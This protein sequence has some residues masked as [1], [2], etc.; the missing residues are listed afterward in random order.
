M[1]TT[2]PIRI[3]IVEDSALVRQG[4]TSLL[5][6]STDPVMQVVGE[7]TSNAEAI[8]A[9]EEHKPDVVLLDIRLPDGPGFTACKE[10][11]K[12]QPDTRII[13]L[14]SHSSD[15]FVYE[16]VSAGVH[17]YLM[18]EIDPDGLI[19]GIR[20]VSEGKSI[21]APDATERVLNFLRA[22]S[23]SPNNHDELAILSPQE[24]K[25]LAL[26]ADGFTNKQ[27][28]SSLNLSE[29]TVK[30]YLISVFEKLNVKRRAQ[31][32]AVYVQ[33]TRTTATEVENASRHPFS[34]TSGFSL[35]E[36]MVAAFVM[37]LGITTAITTLQQGLKAVDSAR[38]YSY[39]AQLMQSELERLRLKSWSQI[40]TL[41]NSGS[42]KVTTD[43]TSSSARTVFTCKRV[44]TDVKS[45]MKEI[46]VISNWQGYDGRPHTARFITR[47]SKSGLYDYIYTAH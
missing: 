32:A 41:Q 16:A 4:V 36:V 30:N 22:G 13:I 21:L 1:N 24:K 46:T 19:Q 42:T 44:I 2:S 38:N 43:D 6:S 7:A 31:A 47:Y 8:S 33:N 45:D 26:V 28:G 17:G 18:K 20:D 9:C 10:I 12:R 14:T 27:V 3:L 35:V 40:Q 11:L 29:N 37:V 23:H 15:S 5:S 34:Q 25:V 39:A